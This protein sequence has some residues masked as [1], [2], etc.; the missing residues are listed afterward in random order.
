MVGK[1]LYLVG[2]GNIRYLCDANDREEAKRR[3]AKWI[4]YENTPHIPVPNPDQFVV[5]P[6][7]NHGDRIKLDITLSI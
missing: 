4:C 6:L 2:F 3:A 1:Q 7:T 5:T